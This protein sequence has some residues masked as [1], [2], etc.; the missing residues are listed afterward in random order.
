MAIEMEMEHYAKKEQ[1]KELNNRIEGVTT[2]E[3]FNKFKK[4]IQTETDYINSKFKKIPLI[5]EMQAAMDGAKT[6]AVE[7]TKFSSKKTD[8]LKDREGLLKVIGDIGIQIK[9]VDDKVEN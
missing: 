4:T 5:D 8:C 6:F 7:M 3:S 1:I 9:A 2:I